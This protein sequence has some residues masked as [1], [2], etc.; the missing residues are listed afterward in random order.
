MKILTQEGRY[1]QMLC[2]DCAVAREY[3]DAGEDAKNYAIRAN[4]SAKSYRQ[5]LKNHRQRDAL[6]GRKQ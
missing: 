1:Q 6:R 2:E 5:A 3:E 4:E